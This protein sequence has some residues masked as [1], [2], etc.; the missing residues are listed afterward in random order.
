VLFNTLAIASLVIGVNLAASGIQS[1]V[2]A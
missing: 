2:D 1:A